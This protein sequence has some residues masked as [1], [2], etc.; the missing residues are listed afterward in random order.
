MTTEEIV[1]CPNGCGTQLPVSQMYKHLQDCKVSK[2][3]VDDILK[4][5]IFPSSQTVLPPIKQ[6]QPKLIKPETINTQY[7]P[8]CGSELIITELYRV[9]NHC[10]YIKVRAKIWWWFM[11]RYG[12]MIAWIC[13][14]GGFIWGLSAYHL[15]GLK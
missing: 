13:L 3:N 5:Y 12:L 14:L 7:C 1:S 10:K 11:L 8:K 4:S 6:E 2:P 15:I 9:C